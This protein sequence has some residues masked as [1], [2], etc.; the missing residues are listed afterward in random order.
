MELAKTQQEMIDH[1]KNKAVKGR[2]VQDTV[3]FLPF[4]TTLSNI[5]AVQN[6]FSYPMGG[7]AEEKKTWN[8]TYKDAVGSFLLRKK[9]VSPENMY[10]EMDI[11]ILKIERGHIVS[12]YDTLTNTTSYHS[13]GAGYLTDDEK[14]RW[15]AKYPGCKIYAKTMRI[16]GSLANTPEKFKEMTEAGESPLFVY[17]VK[18]GAWGGWIEAQKEMDMLSMESSYACRSSALTIYSWGFK[19]S[20]YLNEEMQ[21]P[22]YLPLFEPYLLTVEQALGFESYATELND[23]TTYGEPA[24]KL[25]E[26]PPTIPTGTR[27]YPSPA[28]VQK[29]ALNNAEFEAI[30]D[31]L[32]F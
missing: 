31:D 20:T 28:S 4:V 22:T 18:G 16:I 9:P 14:A 24:E 21:T 15:S 11:V 13:V 25:E 17:E 7:S 12:S 6:A 32:P 3:P 10:K 8:E 30:D 29:Q 2:D 1:L 5:K 23:F 27:V 19:L 26:L